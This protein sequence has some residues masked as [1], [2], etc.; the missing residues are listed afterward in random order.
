MAVSISTI[1]KS[2]GWARSDVILA[3]EEAF[4]IVEFHGATQSGIVTF[5]TQKNGGEDDHN[6]NQ[7]WYDVEAETTSGI[8]TGASFDIYRSGGVVNSIMINRPGYGILMEN[9]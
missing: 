2:A 1:T 7:Y 4:E 8:G 6:V 9:T 3:L 5:I